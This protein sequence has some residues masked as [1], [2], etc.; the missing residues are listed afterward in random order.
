[1][2]SQ[3][4]DFMLTDTDE[5]GE[6][7]DVAFQILNIVSPE[8]SVGSN[9]KRRTIQYQIDFADFGNAQK[10]LIGWPQVITASDGTMAIS[11]HI[12]HSYT[13]P[14]GAVLYC[15][16]ITRAVGMQ[17]KAVTNDTDDP[18]QFMH[19]TCLYEV[20]PYFIIDD[21]TLGI[22]TGGLVEIGTELFRY[23]ELGDVSSTSKVFKQ[24]FGGY[25]FCHSQAPGE[26]LADKI[27][28]DDDNGETYIV[29]TGRAVSQGVPFDYREQIVELIWHHIP[30]DNAPLN[31]AFSIQNQCND[32]QFYIWESG[33]VMLDTIKPEFTLEVDGTY[34]WKLRYRFR[35]NM[36]GWNFMPDPENGNIFTRIACIQD[37]RN[38][39]VKSADFTQLFT[40]ITP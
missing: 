21:D 38:D 12:P 1:M 2:A 32:A 10:L 35:I 15:T 24:M 13:D 39:L 4:Q 33:T 28:V 14:N 25:C 17:P 8:D 9:S 31:I 18:Y 34:S 20:L 36:Q 37:P 6:S 5:L 40:P 7:F 23:I 30:R 27:I 19:I 3:Y 11:R 29:D 16:G 22:D 26:T